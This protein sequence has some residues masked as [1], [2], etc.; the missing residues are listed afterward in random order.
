MDNRTSELI[1]AEPVAFFTIGLEYNMGID[2]FCIVFYF[3]HLRTI[4]KFREKISRLDF[5]PNRTQI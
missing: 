2:L 1:T 4:V 5:G 3:L